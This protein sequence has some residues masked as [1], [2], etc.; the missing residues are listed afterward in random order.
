MSIRKQP[1]IHKDKEG[2]ESAPEVGRGSLQ[3][4]VMLGS[5]YTPSLN[6]EGLKRQQS[7]AGNEGRLLFTT[8]AKFIGN[9]VCDH[10]IDCPARVTAVR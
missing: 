2:C 1:S 8:N 5:A 10:R 6:C 4:D 3:E 7:S 9:T